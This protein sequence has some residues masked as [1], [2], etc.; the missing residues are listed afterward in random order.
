MLGR[1]EEFQ[2]L[3]LVVPNHK[4]LICSSVVLKTSKRNLSENK[5]YKSPCFTNNNIKICLKKEK[6]IK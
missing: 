3:G 2:T 6:D 1:S 5:Q 4:I